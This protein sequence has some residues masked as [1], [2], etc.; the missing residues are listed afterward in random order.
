MGKKNCKYSALN[1]KQG[2]ISNKAQYTD[3]I[4]VTEEIHLN[5]LTINVNGSNSPVKD[6]I[7]IGF[8]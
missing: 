1:R 6:L 3:K 8:Y 2:D 5:K 7:L 4:N